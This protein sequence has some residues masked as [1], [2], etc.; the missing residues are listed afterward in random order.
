[1]QAI[2][3]YPRIIREIIGVNEFAKVQMQLGGEKFTNWQKKSYKDIL[4]HDFINSKHEYIYPCLSLNNNAD[5]EGLNKLVEI[6]VERSKL[7][8]KNNKIAMIVKS[9][10]GFVINQIETG[11]NYEDFIEKM[12]TATFK[13]KIPFEIARYKTLLKANF[14]DHAERIDFANIPD[15]QGRPQQQ[16]ENA[17]LN[18]INPNSG[19]LNL[20]FGSLLPW[21]NLPV[22]NNQNQN[23][24]GD[25]DNESLPSDVEIEDEEYND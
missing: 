6:Y 25:D 11:F 13:Y 23:Q 12:Y 9:C 5:I 19:L 2:L 3:L 15:V 24:N 21:N 22:A 1:L 8:W 14:S 18:P 4:N 20:I 7:I 16:N 17:N 10:L